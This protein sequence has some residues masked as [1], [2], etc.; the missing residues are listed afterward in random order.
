VAALRGHAQVEAADFSVAFVVVAV[1]S[2]A[3]FLFNIRLASNAGAE[4]AGRNGA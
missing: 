4:V 3:S 1:V 2:A